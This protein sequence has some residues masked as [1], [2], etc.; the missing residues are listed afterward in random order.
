[1]ATRAISLAFEDGLTAGG[2]AVAGRRAPAGSDRVQIR[3]DDLG[4]IVF[5][6]MRRHGGAGNAIL[7][8]LDQ[9]RLRVTLAESP[10]AEIDARHLIAIRAVAQNAIGAKKP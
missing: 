6:I 7:N 2:V 5:Q 10:V 8:D 4:A 1:M 3:Q 9:C